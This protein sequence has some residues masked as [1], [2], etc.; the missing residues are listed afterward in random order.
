MATTIHVIPA[1]NMQSLTEKL[2]KLNRKASKL[3]TGS[4]TL[5]EI[6]REPRRIQ[7]PGDFDYYREFV[8]IEVGGPAP[9]VNGWTFVATLEHTEAGNIVRAV[10]GL[11]AE[12][13]LNRYRE[14]EALCEH[15]GKRRY[16]LDSFVLRSDAGAYKQIGRNCL[17]DFLGHDS[18][19]ALASWAEYLTQATEGAEESEGRD[20]GFRPVESF[21]ITSVAAL[22][23]A[24]VRRFGYVSRARAEEENRSST[25]SEV[26]TA[27]FSRGKSRAG[28]VDGELCD[29]RQ[30]YC[31]N[32]GG[33]VGITP[34]DEERAAKALAWIRAVEN[35]SDYLYNL[36]IACTPDRVDARKIGL[37][38]SLMPAYAYTVERIEKQKKET[39]HTPALQEWVG[40]VG[41]RHTFH[42]LK[43]TT[44]R[45]IE[46]DYGVSHLL[47]F[48]DNAGHKYKWFSSNSCPEEGEVLTITATVKAH[49]EYQ[50]QHITVLTRGKLL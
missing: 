45:A 17:R 11:T 13:E 4:I 19:E 2:V 28:A 26:S 35:P 47:L 42:G 38:A 1:E 34:P 50:G 46:G 30:C 23:A 43:V 12:G 44:V 25:A 49:E 24:F 41:Q 16:R 9:K 6:G 20:Y 15:C 18:P 22:A 8:T 33:H 48:V 39:Q 32:W 3:G 5:R 14:G 7:K 10:P 27:L 36:H 21:P 29:D 37:V 40:T 31:H